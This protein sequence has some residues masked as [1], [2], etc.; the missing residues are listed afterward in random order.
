MTPMQVDADI[1]QYW[2]SRDEITEIEGILFKGDR[3]IVPKGMRPHILKVIHESHLGMVKCKQLARDVVYW[4]SKNSQI[5]EIVSRC[6][7]C[8]ERRNQ[9]PNQVL[10][11]SEIPARPWQTVEADLLHCEGTNF[12]VVAD[13]FS[14]FIEVVELKKKHIQSNYKGRTGKAIF[15]PWKTRKV[16]Y[17]QWTSVS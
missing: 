4:P 8:Q 5:E 9:P 11:P 17:R 2:D 13:Y 1:R 3:V 6:P 16:Y 10:R 15:S 14:N 12:L 7:E